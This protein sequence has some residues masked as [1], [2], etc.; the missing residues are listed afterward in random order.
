MA[1]HEDVYENSRNVLTAEGSIGTIGFEG[2][3]TV[4]IIDKIYRAARRDA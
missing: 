1:H 3:K 4:Q 2:L